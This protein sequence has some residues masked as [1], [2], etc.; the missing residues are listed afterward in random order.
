MAIVFVVADL[1]VYLMMK[2]GIIRSPGQ[3]REGS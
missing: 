3:P 2:A 1:G